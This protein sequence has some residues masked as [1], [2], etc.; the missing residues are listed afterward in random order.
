MKRNATECR[1]AWVAN[2]HPRINHAEW[3]PAELG[4]LKSFVM[5]YQQR[6][7]P[8]DWVEVSEKLGVNPTAITREISTKIQN[9]DQSH[10]GGVYE[11]ES[12]SS[13]FK[14]DS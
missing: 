1:I 6:N 11:K 12:V 14:L 10:S 8:I 5:E 2:R 3:S 7:A 9:L 13:S 4:T